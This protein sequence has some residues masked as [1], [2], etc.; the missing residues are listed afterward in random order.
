MQMSIKEKAARAR[1]PR[2]R[3]TVAV[4][5]LATFIMPAV[6]VINSWISTRE[7]RTMQ[8]ILLREKAANIAAQLEVMNPE[9]I[10]RGSFD[11]LLDTEPALQSLH[12]FG[13]AGA[14]GDPNVE[15]IRSGR[16]LYRTL[17]TGSGADETYTSYIPFHSRDGLYVA[18]IELSTSGADMVLT[19]ARHNLLVS[20]LSGLLLLAVSAFALWTYRRASLLAQRQ[21]Q[22]ERLAELG[23]LSAVLAHEIRNPLGAIKGFAQLARENADSAAAKPLDAIVRESLRL[24]ALVE[25]LLLYARPVT[26]SFRVTEWEAFAEELRVHAA[27][28]IGARPIRFET[29][30][31][32]ER[33]STDPNLLKQALLNLVRNAVE[34]I[35][36]PDPG[37]VRLGARR[38]GEHTVEITVT[39]NGAGIPEAVHTKLFSPFLTTK[40]SGT[41]LGLPVSKKIIE[42]L[43]GTLSIEAAEQR[44]TRAKVELHGSNSG[45]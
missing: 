2:S 39:D 16:E 42:S 25:S 6:L 45:N 20:A 9:D 37:E 31:D 7:L 29:E 43:G 24:E 44:G 5:L 36:N 14:S 18:R 30:S 8:G 13:P 3:W 4:L 32:I 1:W 26:P 33:F 11:S 40:A 27:S 35:P 41:G 28:W 38:T 10:N 34:S 21:L 15:A 12:A 19:H 17:R 23:T 22:A